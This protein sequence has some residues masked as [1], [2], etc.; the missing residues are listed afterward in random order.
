[1]PILPPKR[2]K[3]KKVG[4]PAFSRKDIPKPF[5]QFYELYK[6]GFLNKKEFS[7]FL[8]VSRPTLDRYFNFINAKEPVITKSENMKIQKELQIGTSP[9][10]QADFLNYLMK[11]HGI[12]NQSTGTYGNMSQAIFIL[13]YKR[14]ENHLEEASSD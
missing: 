9:R 8:G 3:K 11:L 5:F 1:M 12:E 14:Q 7:E 10:E 6:F 2:R 13:Q 4:R